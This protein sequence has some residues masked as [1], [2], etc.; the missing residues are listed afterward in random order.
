MFN[1]I[2]KFESVHQIWEN[3][4]ITHQTRSSSSKWVR[5]VHVFGSIDFWPVHY[6]KS[7]FS[8]SFTWFLETGAIADQSRFT[9]WRPLRHVLSQHK[10]RLFHFQLRVSWNRKSR[11]PDRTIGNT[12][13]FLTERPPVRS[14]GFNEY[15]FEW[16]KW[17]FSYFKL[18][19]SEIGNFA[20]Q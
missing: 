9:S 14:S 15:K 1:K 12:N 3:G 11:N 7:K 13:H 20:I 17:I 5:R 6:L 4:A 2:E 16:N 10:F 8:L 19:M 18:V